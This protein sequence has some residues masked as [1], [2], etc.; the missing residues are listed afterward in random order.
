M[1]VSSDPDNSACFLASSCS[2]CFQSFIN[3]NARNDTTSVATP[4]TAIVPIRG[5][6]AGVPGADAVADEDEDLFVA[7]CAVWDGDDDEDNE[8]DAGLEESLVVALRRRR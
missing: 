2:S 1:R 6:D 7:V 4:A 8:A 3:S 5:L